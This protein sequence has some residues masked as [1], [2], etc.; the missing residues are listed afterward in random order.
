MNFSDLPP[1]V[2]EALD[3]RPNDVPGMT[4][5][6]IFDA[7]CDYEG[8]IHW[9]PKLRTLWLELQRLQ[10]IDARRVAARNL[11]RHL[12]EQDITGESDAPQ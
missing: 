6:E 8:L 5:G 4:I 9:G 10:S 3:N 2:K 7:W 12:R 1:P 11:E